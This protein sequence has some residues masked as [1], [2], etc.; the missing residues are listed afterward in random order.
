[1]EIVI[2]DIPIT[3]ISSLLQVSIF[4]FLITKTIM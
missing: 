4:A 3:N 2:E 1:M